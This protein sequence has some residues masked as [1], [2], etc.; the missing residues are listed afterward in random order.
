SSPVTALEH[1][2]VVN[3]S[4]PPNAP[5][6]AWRTAADR[7]EPMTK[8]WF[9]NRCKDIFRDHGLQIM[10]GHSLHIGGTTWLLLLG[11]DPWITK[12]IG[13]W[14]SAA[15]LTYWHKIE[16]I[17]PDFISNA[18]Q[19]VQTLSPCMSCFVSSL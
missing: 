17:L 13:C 8:E 9:I 15:F 3:H 19:V 11:V 1:H 10:D 18:Y 5:L 7:W 16:Q 2:L 14:S 4:V 6:F 12:V